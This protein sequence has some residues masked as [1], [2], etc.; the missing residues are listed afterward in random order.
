MSLGGG[1]GER[2]VVVRKRR[3]S[4][5]PFPRGGR[6]GEWQRQRCR[7][8]MGRVEFCLIEGR[9]K[10][11][12]TGSPPRHWAVVSWRVV[13]LEGAKNEEVGK[14]AAIRSRWIDE[15]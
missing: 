15:N 2:L 5:L 8:E 4:R 14:G 1:S 6:R 12:L 9:E 10:E 7:R 3:L 13:W 11:D